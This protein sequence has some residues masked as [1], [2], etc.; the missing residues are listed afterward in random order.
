MQREIPAKWDRKE[1][2]VKTIS[3]MDGKGS[4][5]TKLL[6]ESMNFNEEIDINSTTV[7]TCVSGS[8]RRV[9]RHVLFA[10]TSSVSASPM[11]FCV[12]SLACCFFMYILLVLKTAGF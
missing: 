6:L 8:F 2:E 5:G 4:L 1:P 9:Y 10:A 12:R 3:G 7:P 11:S